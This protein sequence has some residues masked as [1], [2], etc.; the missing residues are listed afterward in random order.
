MTNF[1][2]A[3]NHTNYFKKDEVKI[4]DDE[5]VKVKEIIKKEVEKELK[6]TK[7]DV[8]PNSEIDNG[9]A[10]KFIKKISGVKKPKKVK[11]SINRSVRYL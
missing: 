8:E 6:E 10:D 7:F 2:C 5:Q 3:V 9:F 1:D 4:I 11:T